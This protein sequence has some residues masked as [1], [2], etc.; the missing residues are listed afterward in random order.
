MATP[1]SID[2]ARFDAD[3]LTG[4]VALTSHIDLKSA[5]DYQGQFRLRRL[6]L[7]QLAQVLVKPGEEPM[8]VSGEVSADAT[9]SGRGIDYDAALNALQADGAVEV[10][11]GD[12]FHIPVLTD[13]AQ[14]LQLGGA[15]TVGDA[16]CHFK[17]ADRQIHL[18]QAAVGAPA[19]GVQGSGTIGLDGALDLDLI[20]TGFNDW[21]RDIRGNDDNA[22]A[23]VAAS[24]AGIVQK[25]FNTLTRELIYQMHVDGTIKDPQVH[26][27]AAPVLHGGQ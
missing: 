18:S 8:T 16:A 19:V 26:V 7:N 3:V 1:Q 13:V 27:V 9:F 11:H 2:I 14:K 22:V 12:L 20:A 24:I 6:D 10:N 21:D 25:G 17:L 4:T 15:G 23:N 5:L